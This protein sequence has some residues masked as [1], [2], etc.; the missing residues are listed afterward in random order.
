MSKNAAIE[1]LKSA[2]KSNE[3]EIGWSKEQAE[4]HE[5]MLAHYRRRIEQVTEEQASRNR[6]LALLEAVENTNATP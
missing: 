6:A 5:R 3:W 4:N 1:S 2:I